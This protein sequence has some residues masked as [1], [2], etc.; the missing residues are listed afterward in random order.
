MANRRYIMK[1]R[2][3]VRGCQ[4]RPGYKNPVGRTFA[5]VLED[6]T[7]EI[8]CSSCKA[9]ISRFECDGQYYTLKAL[10]IAESQEE[11]PCRREKT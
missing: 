7:V 4:D 2:C 1:L 9:A 8:R 3:P 10:P 11:T 6:G 5:Y